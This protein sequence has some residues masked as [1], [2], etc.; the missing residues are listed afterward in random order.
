M[1]I[2]DK[3][4]YYKFSSPLSII[5]SDMAKDDYKNLIRENDFLYSRISM[6]EKENEKLIKDNKEL[7]KSLEKIKGSKGFKAYSLF[8]KI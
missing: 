8:K 7:S 2:E 1:T 4:F 6:L 5:E 3:K